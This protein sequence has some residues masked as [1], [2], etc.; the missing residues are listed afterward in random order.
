MCTIFPWLCKFNKIDKI[1][2]FTE[3]L[4]LKERLSLAEETSRLQSSYIVYVGDYL[5]NIGSDTR[6]KK[7]NPKQFILSE[8]DSLKLS[9][10]F[11]SMRLF[12][13][14]EYSIK[15]QIDCLLSQLN[16]DFTFKE[17]IN[18]Y[19]TSTVIKYHKELVDTL[20]IKK[21]EIKF[22]ENPLVSSKIDFKLRDLCDAKFNIELLKIYYKLILFGLFKYQNII[23]D[24]E[25]NTFPIEN[26]IK[27][28]EDL[29]TFDQC[30]KNHLDKKN[31]ISS[32]KDLFQA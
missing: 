14:K 2:S 16:I 9:D 20:E 17:V 6:F 24:N 3:E 29:N 27:T 21:I 1:M 15:S 25:K 11:S 10:L 31:N 7:D 4:F 18:D 8:E 5:H 26:N 13:F 12:S 23:N 32:I 30:H 22:E 28:I 19:C